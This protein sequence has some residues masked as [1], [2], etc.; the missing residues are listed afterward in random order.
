MWSVV[1]TISQQVLKEDS[2]IKGSA[3]VT[4]VAH[5]YLSAMDK[6]KAEIKSVI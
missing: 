1:E 2:D 4:S 3:K 5:T 6:I